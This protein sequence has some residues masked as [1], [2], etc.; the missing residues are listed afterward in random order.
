MRFGVRIALGSNKGDA[1][2]LVF[3]QG[4]RPVALGIILGFVG[5]VALSH[6]MSFLLFGVSPL[7]PVAFSCASAF[8]FVVAALAAYVPSRRATEVDPMVA[9]RYE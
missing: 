7:D 8:L 5:A 3:K 9:L 6:V 4:M 1:L 2:A